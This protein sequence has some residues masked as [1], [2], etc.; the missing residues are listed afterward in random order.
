MFKIR[1]GK[2]EDARFLAETVMEAVGEELCIDLA[3]GRQRLPL[4]TELF[5]TLAADEMSQYSYRNAFVAIDGEGNPVGAIIV[6]DGCR[7]HELRKSF[8]REANR[9]LGWN[10]TEEEAEEWGDEA[11]PGEIYI[12]SLY[13]VKDARRQG[14]AAALLEAVTERFKSSGK[15]TGLLV[16]PENKTAYHTYV[17]WGFREAGISN[18][19]HTPMIHMQRPVVN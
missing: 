13:V 3:D 16:E 6:Y 9:I 15:P 5:T 1:E 18:F 12:D 4:V 14:V 2:K 17:K 8:I 7:L 19:F 10:V 11:D